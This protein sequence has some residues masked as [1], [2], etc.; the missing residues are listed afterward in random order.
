MKKRRRELGE[1]RGDDI[2]PEKS[3]KEKKT[4]QKSKRDMLDETF[5]SFVNEFF[6]ES[7]DDEE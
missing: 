7:S 5:F 6:L 3:S 2:T 1:E 4:S